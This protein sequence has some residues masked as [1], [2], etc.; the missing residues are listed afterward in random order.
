MTK[1]PQ[2]PVQKQVFW[3]KGARTE[4]VEYGRAKFT[5][6]AL[7]YREFLYVASLASQSDPMTFRLCV[8]KVENL[9]AEK[10]DG[11]TEVLEIKYETVD[12]D[13]KDTQIMTAESF[14]IFD[15]SI[16]LIGQILYVVQELSQL[17]KGE[18]RTA[19]IF[20][21]NK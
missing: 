2:K 6:K 3:G 19:R 12:I 7:T 17:T 11:T 8:T 10:D 20:R 15:E 13:G 9:L 14:A 5:V 4:V 21:K 18:A 1:K 16:L